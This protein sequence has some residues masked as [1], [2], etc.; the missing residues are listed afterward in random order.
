MRRVFS[1]SFFL[2]PFFSSFFFRGGTQRR[3]NGKTKNTDH[4]LFSP[5]HL[6]P[7]RT[8]KQ[9]TGTFDVSLLEVGGGAVEV[10]ST[11]GDAS[12][13]GDDWDAALAELIGSTF[14]SP[15]G[16]TDWKT[17]SRSPSTPSP[18]YA[19][20]LGAARAAKEALSAAP[21]VELTLSSS[22]PSPPITAKVTR[23]MLDQVGEPLFARAAAAID[24]ACFQS[25][26]EIGE[27]VARWR[28]SVARAEAEAKDGDKEGTSSSSS[29]KLRPKKRPPVSRVL[30]VGG[31]TRM[32]GFDAFIENLTGLP[33]TKAK[34]V[35]RE[36]EKEG[37]EEDGNTSLSAA[38]SLGVVD[39]DTSVAAGAALQA[40]MLDGDPAL[41]GVVVLDV[42]Q[43]GLA[44]ALA[45]ARLAA[46][47]RRR[48]AAGESGDDDD[49]DEFFEGVNGGDDEEEEGEF[50]EDGSRLVFSPPPPPPSKT[51]LRK[52][53]ARAAK[54]SKSDGGKE[55]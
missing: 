10:L 38:L 15:A 16:V 9:T 14:L 26:V 55:K 41:S 11:G 24:E 29:F 20:L 50:L 25:G 17:A 43:A 13:G 54:R 30:L 27:S 4:F 22:G 37:G 44:R 8:H 49:D 3:S 32:W 36:E 45:E 48:A 40:A 46:E 28:E 6:S 2:L 12:L 1:F 35:E 51:K 21:A 33:P 34:K 31:G 7:F 39:P 18:A 53:R 23:A 19:S 52:Q 42:W 47:E 5:T